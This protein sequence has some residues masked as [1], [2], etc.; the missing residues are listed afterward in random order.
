M[1]IGVIQGRDLYTMFLIGV[2]L[3][4]AAIPEGLPAIVTVVLALGVQRMIKQTQSC[5]SFLLLKPLEPQ[6]LF[7]QIKLGR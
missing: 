4:V 7:V 2:S 5:E 3:A 6:R 1:V